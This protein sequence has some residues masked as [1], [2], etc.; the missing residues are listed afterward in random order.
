ML[1]SK[2]RW[3]IPEADEARIMQLSEQLQVT[4]LLARLLV[5]RGITDIEQARRFL[6]VREDQLHD[7]FLLDGMQ[8]AV[9]RIRA[10]IRN[11]EKIRIYGD[12]DADGVTSTSLMAGVLQLLGAHYDYYIPHRQ[13]EGYG[14]NAAAVELAKQQ[15]VRLIVTVD[16]GISAAEEAEL[17]AELG[18]DLIVTDHHEPPTVL[19]QAVAV[20]NPRKP[21]CP[22]PFKSLAG[23]GVAFKLAHALLGRIPHEWLE[24]AAIGTIADLMPLYD[25]NRVIVK[26][27]LDCIQTTSYAGIRALFRASGIELSEV[28]A[29]HIGFSIAPRI[30]ASGRLE[31]ADLAVRC[32]TTDNE[33]E[34]EELAYELDRLNR[35]RQQIVEDIVQEALDQAER[36]RE[37][38]LLD[39]VL[40]LFGEGWNVGVVGIVASKVLDKYYRPVIVL[41]VDPETQTAKGSARSIPGFDMYAAL[42]E[43][44][45]VLDHY[46]GHQAA[47]GMTLQAA[48]IADL[49]RR[50]NDIADRVLKDDDFIP[51]YKPDAEMSIEEISTE[52]IAELDA[53]APFG[54]KNPRP[55]FVVRH[56]GIKEM[57]LLGKDRQHMKFTLKPLNKPSPEIEALAFGKAEL[58]AEISESSTIELCVELTI[59]EWNG[60]RKPQMMIKDV[61]V[62]ERQV[63]DW[64]GKKWSD[65]AVISWLQEG[66]EA[67]QQRGMLLFHAD[68]VACTPRLQ[69]CP[70]AA[71][72]Y[73]AGTLIALNSAAARSTPHNI[74][75]LLLP[76][77]P[78][79]V[80]QCEEGLLHFA[81]MNRLYAMLL[82]TR[83]YL[84]APLPP[85]E[86]FVQVYG[87][88][89]Q[90][91]KPLTM[92]DCIQLLQQKTRLTSD[93]IRFI[94]AVFESLAFLR[95]DEGMLVLVSSPHK[96][97]LQDSAVFMDKQNRDVVEQIFIYSSSQEL[98]D[99]LLS[100]VD[101]RKLR[102]TANA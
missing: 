30:N 67:V 25:E 4:P 63:F 15:G 33:Q 29:G 94:L 62:K 55:A 92:E 53:L 24:F 57:K 13:T 80:R 2:A 95:V 101:P 16:T 49:H 45:D 43:C 23:V 96:R 84:S 12:Y 40:V 86:Q 100:R 5:V 65:Q 72:R 19:P 54:M 3:L 46:G 52:F 87:W 51:V 90:W 48:C 21:G 82:D 64:R 93:S 18:M 69:E 44:E 39:K 73:A 7:P 77:L 83:D 85:R 42:S 36:L 10:A 75:H 81:E 58:Q 27:G 89:K 22:Y 70:T 38:G 20:L 1:H 11:E 68:D 78:T 61:C 28:S 37:K 97:D 9:D 59:N 35:E 50:L 26:L 60:N 76:E 32:L 102:H 6:S 14:L 41:S 34:A 71:W 91:D 56:A 47:A 79:D 88:L 17:I 66:G 31:R 99:W 98:K 74:K 8:A